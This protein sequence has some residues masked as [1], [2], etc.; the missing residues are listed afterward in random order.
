MVS[1]LLSHH[2]AAL[3]ASLAVL[4]S[5]DRATAERSLAAFRARVLARG[6]RLLSHAAKAPPVDEDFHAVRRAVRKL[7]YASEWLGRDTSD[8]RS[9]QQ[10]FGDLNDRAV[11][12]RLLQETGAAPLCLSHAQRLEARLAAARRRALGVWTRARPRIAGVRA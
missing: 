9:V 4:P 1:H 5:L 7:R 12:A 10:V 11:E 6:D 8:I 3:R 2:A